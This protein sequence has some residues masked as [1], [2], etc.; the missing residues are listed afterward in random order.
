MKR[1]IK[2]YYVPIL[3]IILLLIN[4]TK[5]P[6]YIN[7]PGGTIDITD[8]I[9]LDNKKK[10]NNGTLNMLYV[11]E[12]KATIPTYI[13]SYI[14]KDWDIEKIEEQK[15]GK[16]NIEDIE[17]RNKIMLKNSLNNA[18][19]NAYKEAGK[20][21]EIKDKKN[22]IIAVK[23]NKELKTGDII[24]EINNNKINNIY[25]I[26]ENLKSTKANNKINIKIKRDNQK[27][28]ITTSLNNNKELGIV[29][30]TDFNYKI[31]D[32]IKIKFKKNESGASGGLMMA[33]TIYNAITNEDII[34]GKNIAGTGTI[35]INGNI[36]EIDGI[37][38]KIMGAE[39]NNINTILL[40]VENYKEAQKIV[41]EKNYN[42]KLV[43][44][45]TFSEAINYLK[46]N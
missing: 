33:L 45:K 2:K 16:E 17:K 8:R 35:D 3:F 9:E 42:I 41:K 27:K 34:K 15:I 21:I 40:P 37:K 20:K 46:K 1:I 44:V 24:E 36:G 13:L 31:D 28:E 14:I 39:K 23:D 22:I 4:N 26:K 25:E 5:L 19:Y 32:D 12:Y 11:K 6:Y 30:L 29:V 38:Y 7:T 18:I 43:P 10:E